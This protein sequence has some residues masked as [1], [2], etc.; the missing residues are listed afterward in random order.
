MALPTFRHIHC[1]SRFD[2]SPASLDFDLTV[3][4]QECSLITLTEITNDRRA[5]QM[6]EAGWEYYNHSIG[7]DSDNC[8][9]CWRKDTWKRTYGKILVLESVPFDRLHGRQGVKLYAATV[10]LK[11]VDT[12]HKLLVSVTHMPAHIEGQGG[13]RTD[14]EGWAA[15][16]QAYLQGLT[17]WRVHVND[18]VRKRDIDGALIVADWNLNLKAQWVREMLANHWGPSW[19]QAWKVFASSGG[20]LHGG[21]DVP[22]D[23]PGKGHHDR[24]IDGSLYKGLKVAVDPVQMARV[25]SSD[26]R[27]YKETFQ[28]ADKAEHPVLEDGAAHGDT[29]HGEAWWGFGDYMDDELYFDPKKDYSTG[30]AGGEVL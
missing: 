26:H 4:Q 29:Y 9:I 1:S 10:V 12:G 2:R 19:R 22:A 23:A 14:T 20:A 15:R 6:R 17:G 8:G 28:F 27:P 21:P 5:V 16:K 24:V 7:N 3:W 30:E 25:R 13:F 18:M 11:R